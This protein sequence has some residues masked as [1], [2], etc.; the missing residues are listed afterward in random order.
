MKRIFMIAAAALLGACG[1]SQAPLAP[2]KATTA[3][4]LPLLG[5]AHGGHVFDSYCEGKPD[6]AALPPDPRSLVLPGVNAGK[7]VYFNANWRTCRAGL[8]PK[9]C[10]E[11]RAHV[12][13]GRALVGASGAQGAGYE[14]GGDSPSGNY[15]VATDT[16]N[17]LWQQWGLMARPDNFDQLVEE[18]YGAVLSATRNPYPLPGEDPN[19][20]NGGS[21]QLPTAFTQLHNADGSWSGKLGVTCNV[22]HSGQVGTSADGPG[23]GSMYGTNSLH[24]ISL[25]FRE[26]GGAHTGLAVA[27][28]NRVR[29][30]GNI[31]NFQLF[32]LLEITDQT[33]TSHVDPRLFTAPSTGTEDPPVWWNV[34]HRPLKFF[35]AGLP[36]DATRIE[37]SWFYPGAP[38]ANPASAQTFVLAHE[39]DST[40]WLAS[41]KAPLYPGAIDTNLAQAGA[42]LFHVKNL[43]APEL[44]NPVRK[45]DGGNGSCA[46]CHGAYS[47]RFV[48]DPAFLDTPALEGMAAYVVPID[49]IGTDSR[50]LDGNDAGVVESSRNAWFAYR[51]VPECGNQNDPA[52]RGTRPL[53][54]LAPPLYGVWATAPY[55]HNGSVPNAWEV[56]KPA[57]R[58]PIWRRVSKPAQAGLVMGFDTDLARA[59]DSDKIGWKYE[60]IACGTGTLPLVECDPLDPA[61][62]PLAQVVLSA[63]YANGGV[64]WNFA[65]L[66]VLTNEQIEQRKIYNTHFYSQSNAGHEFTSVL[67]DIERR[68]LIEYLKTL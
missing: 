8:Y 3:K 57:D 66:P 23:L 15:T 54:Y 47:P 62:D 2:D 29:G 38:M 48:N 11:H 55:L 10:G 41:L 44:N 65:N 18:R 56:M 42:I 34:G 39:Q 68:A 52:L 35:D 64:L 6:D 50:R 28:L 45:P 26:L 40:S 17:N 43:W 46:S 16:Y 60:A 14:F 5:S 21:G 19:A 22:C 37:L 49:L 4:D 27:S 25:L 36:M 13:R 20:T 24:D 33:T 7:A 30:T 53:G 58:Q 51:D 63:L 61:A 12:E 31:T 1:N 67:T 9:T 32:L 59:Y